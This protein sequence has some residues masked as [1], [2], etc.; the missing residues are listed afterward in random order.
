MSNC[1]RRHN[2]P[3]GKQRLGLNY[4]RTIL[5]A[6]MGQKYIG[7]EKPS[8]LK[9]NTQKILSYIDMDIILISREKKMRN[10]AAVTSKHIMLENKL[11]IYVLLLKPYPHHVAY[12]TMGASLT[13]MLITFSSSSSCP[14]PFVSVPFLSTTVSLPLATPECFNRKSSTHAQVE[15]SQC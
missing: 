9:Q 14:I 10:S 2:M 6:G 8:R 12:G 4:F 3:Q 13:V 5:G 15:N 1:R 11:T 7:S